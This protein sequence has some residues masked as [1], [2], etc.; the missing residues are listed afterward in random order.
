MPHDVG[1]E[2]LPHG[3]LDKH[4]DR[5][6]VKAVSCFILYICCVIIVD[7]SSPFSMR[8]AIPLTDIFTTFVLHIS[9]LYVNI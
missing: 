2:V 7:V 3:L 1:E 6:H 9:V 5:M 8:G 4:V